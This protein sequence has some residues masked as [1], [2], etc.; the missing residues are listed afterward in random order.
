MRKQD[1]ESSLAFH[2]SKTDNK[3]SFPMPIETARKASQQEL[4]QQHPT[5]ERTQGSW[6]REH[7]LVNQIAS[8]KV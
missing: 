4:T 2:N 7:Q 1:N 6:R 3:Q 8:N 5:G